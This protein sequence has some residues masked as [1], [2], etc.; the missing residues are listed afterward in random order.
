LIVVVGLVA[1]W[2]RSGAAG[3]MVP[4]GFVDLPIVESGLVDPTAMALAPDGRVFITQQAGALRVV[5]DGQLVPQPFLTVAVEDTGERG[6]LGVTLD[7]EF[8][9][10]PYVYIYYTV[11][12]SP[13]PHNRVSR[14]EADGNQAVPG[15]ETILLEL[16]DLTGGAAH[17][18]GALHFGTDGMLYIAVGENG[19]G[20][21]AQTLNNLLGKM[22]R[23]NAD[24]SIP[25]DNPFYGTA[26]GDNRA[27]WAL[28][29][30]NPFTF[31]VQPGTGRIFIND[32]GSLYFEEI[33]E[34]TAGDNF[35]WPDTEGMTNDPEFTSPLLAY[36]HGIGPATGCA[37]TGGAFYN[38]A[39]NQFPA[40]Y[41]GDY[42]YAD[43]CSKWIRHYDPV[44]LNNMPFATSLASPVDLKVTPDGSLYY[45][46]RNPDEL[47]RIVYAPAPD[48]DGDGCSDAAEIGPNPV[49]G[50]QRDPG[51]VWDFMDQWIG[52]PFSRDK[53]VSGGDLGSVVARYG[54][55]G[56]PAGDPLAPPASMHGYHTMADRAGSIPGGD[57]W[58]LQPPDG[59]V[60]GQDIG[61]TV[62]QYGHSCL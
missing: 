39:T 12:S 10:E 48:A 47:H 16:N 46:A 43:F 26:T 1:V 34:A 30:R 60:S 15:S 62:V 50:G 28:G 24:G 49:L 5:E 19:I 44:T 9:D 57:P 58:D 18:G 4:S 2:P 36:G 52:S 61:V 14:F 42:F 17:N 41:T 13:N 7:P 21:N 38:P 27:I 33:N 54:S 32:V 6:L 29:L 31:D 45:L 55:V 40:T 53:V 35:G 3:G 37:I 22:L 59:S 11:D 25:I 20:A 51:S 56:N 23:I 8:P